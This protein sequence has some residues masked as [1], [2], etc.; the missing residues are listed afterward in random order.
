MNLGIV[1]ENKSI[2]SHNIHIPWSYLFI[3][4]PFNGFPILV[5]ESR[6][7]ERR[8]RLGAKGRGGREKVD[9]KRKE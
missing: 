2:L 5:G 7:G 6:V 3:A 8:E 1:V 9:M 4:G